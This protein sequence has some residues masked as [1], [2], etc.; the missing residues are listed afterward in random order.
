MNRIGARLREVPSAT[1]KIVGHTDT[2]GKPD[3]NLALSRKRAEAAY[4]QILAGSFIA[5][6]R[7]SFEGKGSIEPL[8]DN[9]RPEGRVFNRTVTVRLAYE[10]K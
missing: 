7:V 1:V 8:F 5:K 6:E 9:G 3:Y 4:D 2:I 10:Q